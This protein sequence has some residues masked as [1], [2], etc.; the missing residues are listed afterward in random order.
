MNRVL[1]ILL[2]LLTVVIYPQEVDIQ[3]ENLISLHPNRPNLWNV[4]R[5]GEANQRN[6]QTKYANRF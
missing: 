2:F 3:L 4:S 1:I 6:P 5:R